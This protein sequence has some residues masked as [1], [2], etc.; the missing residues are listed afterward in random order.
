[1]RV[2]RKVVWSVVCLVAWMVV[3]WVVM[4]AAHLV[5]YSVVW[6]VFGWAV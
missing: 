5:D 1:M 4:L 3:G 6:M 2:A